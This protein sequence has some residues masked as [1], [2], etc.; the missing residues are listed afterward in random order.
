MVR[1]NRNAKTAP[2]GERISQMLINGIDW[3][4]MSAEG[5][6]PI[7]LNTDRGDVLCRYYPAPESAKGAIFVGGAG[8]GFDTPVQGWLYPWLCRQLT[9]DGVACLRV[10]YRCPAD[11]GE[12]ILD[13]LAGVEFLQ[14]EG[15][16]AIAL[17]GHSVG[18]PVIIE[19]AARSSAVRTVL[20]LSTQSRGTEGA[21]RLGPRCSMFLYHGL[22][23]EVLP[24]A[25]SQ[26][27][28]DVA[29]QP[30][31]LIL[32]EGAR[33]GLDEAAD[34]LPDMIRRWINSELDKALA[35]SIVP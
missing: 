25:C 29:Q 10:R 12:S 19:A 13:V 23:D 9:Q 21:G 31:K 24:P 18:G 14:H 27:V 7:T 16:R 32:R 2:A 33:H 6:T 4:D 30:K 17:T 35:E 20:P 5:Y 15:T 11:L 28:F 8:G 34:E 1:R 22:A 26:R 3:G